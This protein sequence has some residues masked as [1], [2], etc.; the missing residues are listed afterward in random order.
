MNIGN[1]DGWTVRAYR[2]DDGKL[3][4][5]LVDDNEEPSARVHMVWLTPEGGARWGDD[6]ERSQALRVVAALRVIAASL[7]SRGFVDAGTVLKARKEIQ[8][9]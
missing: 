8:C 9:H 1:L 7:R 3:T 5:T 2:D 4:A 6:L